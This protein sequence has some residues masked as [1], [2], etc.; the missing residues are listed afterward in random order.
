MYICKKNDIRDFPFSDYQRLT[1][2]ELETKAKEHNLTVYN[3]WM[4]PQLQALFGTFKLPSKNDNGKYNT[5]ELLSANIGKDPH[6]VGIWRVVTKL[7]RSSLVKAQ[8]NPEY[9]QYS[10]LVP[11]ILSGLKKY[12]GVNYSEFDVE[13]LQHLVPADLYEAMTCEY[14]PFSTERLLDLRT[15][16]LTSKTG[17]KAGSM[18][19]PTSAW[20]L[21]G[22]KGTEF[23]NI[24]RLAQTMLTQIWVAHPSIRSPLMVLDPKLWDLMPV[25][26][27]EGS[28][29]VKASK[30]TEDVGDL[31]W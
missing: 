14:E 13:G 30:P 21:T 26:L 23:E 29:V 20:C 12:R 18:K 16:G 19:S 15:H 3:S 8:I 24:P 9:S 10:A 28:S 17:V 2:D 25:P 4:L 7:K 31:P 6:M 1:G 27:V 22:M 5:L 11:L